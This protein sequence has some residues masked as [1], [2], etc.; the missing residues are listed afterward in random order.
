MPDDQRSNFEVIRDCLIQMDP[1]TRAEVIMT[2]RAIRSCRPRDA[3][4]ILASAAR[5]APGPFI[6]PFG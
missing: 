5:P 1:E 3:A 4:K 2:I 6:K